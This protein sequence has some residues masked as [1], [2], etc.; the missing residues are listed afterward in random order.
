MHTGIFYLHLGKFLKLGSRYRCG[1]IF[2]HQHTEYLEIK[3]V[4]LITT[5]E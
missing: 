4:V 5:I 1:Y 2:R 3:T